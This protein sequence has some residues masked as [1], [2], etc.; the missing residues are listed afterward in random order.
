MKATHN[1]PVE[2]ISGMKGFILT[3]SINIVYNNNLTDLKR[4]II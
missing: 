2:F 4:I 3:K 1:D